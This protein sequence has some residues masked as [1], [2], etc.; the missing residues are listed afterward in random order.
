MYVFLYNAE[1]ILGLDV[2][3]HATVFTTPGLSR[4]QHRPFRLAWLRRRRRRRPRRRYFE[5]LRSQPPSTARPDDDTCQPHRPDAAQ[6]WP[7]CRPARPGAPGPPCSACRHGAHT[8]WGR[9]GVSPTIP[10]PPARVPSIARAAILDPQEPP[11]LHEARCRVHPAVHRWGG[12]HLPRATRS[13]PACVSGG[14]SRRVRLR[15]RV[16]DR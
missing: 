10:P 4:S 16:P 12:R 15:A 5:R 13:H 1:N 14:L 3:R 9:E 7:V 2:P 11:H 6:C 8:R